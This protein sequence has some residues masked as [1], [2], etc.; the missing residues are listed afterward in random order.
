MSVVLDTNI[1]TRAAQP[2]H[3]SHNQL[4]NALAMLPTFLGDRRA[5]ASWRPQPGAVDLN[6]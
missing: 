2:A 5:D 6:L 4:L 3:P 1:L